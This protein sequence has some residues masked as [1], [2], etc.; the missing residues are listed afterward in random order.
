M[1]FLL[2]KSTENL[3]FTQ[4]EEL[5]FPASL[6]SLFQDTPDLFIV[7]VHIQVKNSLVVG[8]IDILDIGDKISAFLLFVPEE[9]DSY[10]LD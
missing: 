5:G 2:F 3:K 9:S 4:F 8:N 10:Q 6:F 7:H 1:H